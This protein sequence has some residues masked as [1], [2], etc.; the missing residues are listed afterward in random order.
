MAAYPVLNKNTKY[1]IL[2]CDINESVG[3]LRRDVFPAEN[4]GTVR[5]TD[6][7]RPVREIQ[8]QELINILR[9]CVKGDRYAKT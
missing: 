9:D 2:Q 4:E 5:L 6:K 7:I 1:C 8:R 3:H